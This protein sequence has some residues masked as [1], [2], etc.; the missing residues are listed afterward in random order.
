MRIACCPSGPLSLRSM[1]MVK[2]AWDREDR[3]FIFVSP[4]TPADMKIGYQRHHRSEGLTLTICPT[5]S[6]AIDYIL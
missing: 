3:A 2:M 6:A 4:T 5:P 1:V